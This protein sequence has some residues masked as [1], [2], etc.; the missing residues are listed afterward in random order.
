MLLPTLLHMLLLL[1]LL[2]PLLQLHLLVLLLL[3]LL[4]LLLLL[5]MLLLLN[6]RCGSD[7]SLPIGGE[8]P[9]GSVSPV[10]VMPAVAGV[11]A[12]TTARPTR[13]C[14]RRRHHRRWRWCVWRRRRATGVPAIGGR[15]VWVGPPPPAGG[16]TP[17]RRL[18]QGDCP[19]RVGAAVPPHRHQ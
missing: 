14:L 13:P 9:V 16:D 2:L 11:P 5:L 3:Q 8:P 15:R 1:L 12:V 18:R 7:S 19:R 10:T 6:G 4:L 17:R